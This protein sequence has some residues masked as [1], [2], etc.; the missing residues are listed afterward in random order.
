MKANPALAG[1]ALFR[2]FRLSVSPVTPE[3]WAAILKMAGE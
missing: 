3:E 1:M 2:Q